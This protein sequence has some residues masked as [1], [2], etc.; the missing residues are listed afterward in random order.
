MKLIA[1]AEHDLPFWLSTA[2]IHMVSN[3]SAIFALAVLMV[4]SVTCLLAEWQRRKTLIAV[5]KD[6]PCRTVIVQERGH[7]GP[8]MRIEISSGSD[9][10]IISDGDRDDEANP[11]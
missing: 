5:I 9:D 2:A 1:V 8:A 10:Q 11:A 4:R 3:G 7:G 6:A